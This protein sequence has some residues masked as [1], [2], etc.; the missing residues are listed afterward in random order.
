MIK[1]FLYKF[2][3]KLKLK[4]FRTKQSEKG[5][6]ISKLSKGYLSVNFEGRN[7]VPEG[8]NFSGKIK[9]G[10]AT[11]LG[12]NNMLIGDITIGKYCQFG[13]DIGVHST[14]HPINYLSTYINKNLFNGELK[15]LKKEYK[16]IIGNDVWIGHGVIIVGNV[17]IGNGA[18]LAAGSVITKNVA[19]YS[20]VAGVPGK[21]IKKR[22][23]ENIIK[24]VEELKWWDLS[25]NELNNNKE[26]FFKNFKNANSIY[27]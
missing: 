26:L 4:I 15:K 9:I 6:K 17:K 27:E 3:I 1:F 22:F 10:H 21:V 7:G 2:F 25:E 11:T 18:I 5:T 14:N 24:E 20:I 16:I 13:S 23:S 12:Q 8:C 19:P